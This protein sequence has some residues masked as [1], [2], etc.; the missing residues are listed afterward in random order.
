MND[1][2][3]NESNTGN[4]IKPTRLP[5]QAKPSLVKEIILTQEKIST[6]P[7]IHCH[8][9]TKQHKKKYGNVTVILVTVDSMVKNLNG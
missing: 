1:D 7:I 4:Y 2:I 5:S 6:N 3:E 8:K 9:K